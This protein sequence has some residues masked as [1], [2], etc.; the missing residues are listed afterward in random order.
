MKSTAKSAISLTLVHAG[1][2]RALQRDRGVLIIGLLSS[3]ALL[4]IEQPEEVSNKSREQTS[5]ADRS[6]N[7][8]FELQH[9]G[10]Q[11]IFQGCTSE[12]TYCAMPRALAIPAGV[13]CSTM[14]F[15]SKAGSNTQRHTR[16]CWE[17]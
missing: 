8:L 3:T 9:A 11:F 14:P 16:S 5:G 12:V 1:D 4:T 15:G 10:L 6:R 2:S 7:M 17:P 13:L